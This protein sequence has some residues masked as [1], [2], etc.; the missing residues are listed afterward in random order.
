MTYLA[1]MYGWLVEKT[2]PMKFVATESRIQS[3]CHAL[4]ISDRVF[5]SFDT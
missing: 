1:D 2:E 4:L 3:K 5:C